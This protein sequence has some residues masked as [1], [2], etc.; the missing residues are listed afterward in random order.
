MAQ[1]FTRPFMV[2]TS[3]S[4][5]V[6]GSN[7]KSEIMYTTQ[8]NKD[9]KCCLLVMMSSPCWICDWCTLFVSGIFDLI[10]IG[11]AAAQP[12][13]VIFTRLSSRNAIAAALQKL[14]WEKASINLPCAANTRPTKGVFIALAQARA[15]AALHSK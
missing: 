10:F 5:R 15:A 3:E 4:D 7:N 8:H 14:A 6:V 2:S 9:N 11:G 1:H 13:D 12:F